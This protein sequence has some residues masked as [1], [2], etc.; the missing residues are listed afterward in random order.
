MDIGRKSYI[1]TAILKLFLLHG[2]EVH[3]FDILVCQL[4]LVP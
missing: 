1:P 4:N 3:C 2:L